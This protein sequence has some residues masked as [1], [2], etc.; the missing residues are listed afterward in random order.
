MLSRTAIAVGSL[1]L[2]GSLAA[3]VSFNPASGSNI[4]AGSNVQVTNTSGSAGVAQWHDASGNPVGDPVPVPSGAGGTNVPA[5]PVDGSY[6]LV[7]E[8]L[9]GTGGS[10][11]YQ[12]D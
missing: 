2:A 8:V 11:T 10:A 5:P 4:T 12:V 6:K 1:M 7:V 9:L 3:Q